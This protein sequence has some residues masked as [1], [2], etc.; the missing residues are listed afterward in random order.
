MADW[1]VDSVNLNVD[2]IMT[3][4]VVIHV[5]MS[6]GIVQVVYNGFPYYWN[7]ANSSNGVVVHKLIFNLLYCIPCLIHAEIELSV[8]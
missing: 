3:L 7:I 1:L 2:M 5:F 8:F 4:L 6:D